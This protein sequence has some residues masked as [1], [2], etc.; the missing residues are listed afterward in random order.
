VLVEPDGAA[1]MPLSGLRD[2]IATLPEHEQEPAR[3]LQWAGLV[4]HGRTMPLEEQSVAAELPPNCYTFQPERAVHA[5]RNGVMKD[6][7]D[8]SRVP[9][10]GFGDRQLQRLHGN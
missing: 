10:E 1:G 5:V 9:L 8:G 3:A 6:F 2:W 4:A 7:S